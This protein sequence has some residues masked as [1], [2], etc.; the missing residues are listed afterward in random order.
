MLDWTKSSFS[1]NLLSFNLWADGFI[2]TDLQ[3]KTWKHLKK[4]IAI[5]IKVQNFWILRNDII[6]KVPLFSFYWM[7]P[8][9]QCKM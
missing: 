7:L 8:F 3:I 1:L 2:Q 9:M 4:I 6:L 5:F